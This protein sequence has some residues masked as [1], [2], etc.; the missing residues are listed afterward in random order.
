MME[1]F[2][3][4]MARL[5]ALFRR[6]S[7]LRDIEEELRIHVEME[8]ET[9]IKRGMAP[10]E[11]RAAA[12]KSFGALV[13]NTE[14][15]YD[16]RG[17]GLLETLLQDLRY[18]ARMLL[19]NPGFTMIAVATLSLGIGANTAI[20]SVLYGVLL[21]PLSY[22]DPNLTV[23]V[24]QAAPASGFARLGFSET[25][26]VR[27]RAGNQSFQQLGGYAIRS[28][29]LTDQNE[30]QRIAVAWVTAGV[31][32]SLGVHPALGRAFRQEDEAPGSQRVAIL[33]NEMWRRQY[34][35]DANILGQVIRLDDNPVTVVGVMPPDFRLPE[36]LS[37]PQGAQ[38]WLPV[39]I[40]PA[41]LSGGSYYLQPIARLKPGVRPEQAL[42]EV[43][44]VF[45]QLRQDHPQEA[46]NDP[47][48]NIR[49]L[50]LHSDLVG[51][52]KKALW[53]LV[54]AVGLVLLI[55]CANV[56]SLLLARAAGR[57]KEIAVRAALGAGRGRL[58]RQL[59]TESALIALLGGAGGVTLAAWGVE[60]IAKT[61]LINAPRLS[62][63]SL[64]IT[65]LLFTL[66]I[67][68]VAAALFGLAP[69]A[70]VS[71]IDLNRALREEGRGLAGSAGTNRIQ[72]ALVVSEVAL[73]VML[74]IAAGLLLRSFDR[75]LRIDPGFN[76]KN[77]LTVN[78]D[79]PASRYQDRPRVTAFYDQLLERARALPGVVSAAATSGLP[80]TGTSGDTVFR[81]E[82]RLGSGVVDQTTP[83]NRGAYGHLYFWQVT[84]DYFKTM[85]I[86][87]RQGRALR[88][89]DD[90]NAPPVV[91]INE[92]MA[93]SF[94]PN[95]SPLGKRIQLFS[96]EKRPLAEI[97][98]VVRDVPLRQL[99]EEAKPE[100]Y[101]SP[102]QGLARTPAR[103]MSLVARTAAD[104][105]A[106]AEAVRR[107]VRAL[108]SIVPVFGVSDAEHALGQTVAQPRFNL[109]LLGLFAVVALLLAGVGVYG[110]LANA[111]RQR[112]REIGVRLA[113]G[114]RPGAVFRL[115]IRQGTGLAGVGIGIGLGGSFV[116]TRY[117]ESLLYE[118]KPTD[119]LTFSGVALLLLGVALLACW[120]P[121]RRATK[122]DPMRALRFD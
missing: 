34:S 29:N 16:I 15:G 38:L 43:I 84:P 21:K 116:L 33:S 28:A 121:A 64:N 100:A 92:T 98:G 44:A 4:L 47:G 119:P 2:N 99:N 54:G 83:P 6:E 78:I 67:C 79:L 59:L 97:V 57:H 27:L 26:L 82:G 10:D 36:D 80:L 88:A 42:T 9:N 111:V 90:A 63:V 73:A 1:W 118:V 114:A 11:A 7:V 13:R 102:K 18:G 85:G 117:L 70:Q 96:S 39:R 74:V 56:S 65:V 50:P 108:D 120:I 101:I 113:L 75:L 72:R 41:N 22:P 77:L 25:Q 17:G 5:R 8:T 112:T 53:V 110:V 109:I 122:V 35:G 45:A 106:L 105:L 69:A 94:W 23:R 55:A 95:E 104:P 37:I 68:L 24:W 60:L 49:V 115:V 71:R 46:I 91:V 93:R 86:A 40:D 32:E 51:A 3:I 31:F 58:I 89:S 48:Y 14:L 20:F 103:G 61:N 87:L 30:T 52:V 19:K 62:Q 66:G 12:L 76:V 81:I 107:E